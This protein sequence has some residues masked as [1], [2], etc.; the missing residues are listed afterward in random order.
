M[1]ITNKDFLHKNSEFIFQQDFDTVFGE[2]EF[3]IKLHPEAL[4]LSAIQIGKPFKAFIIKDGNK[5][6]RFANA[7]ISKTKEPYLIKEGCLSLPGEEYLVQRFKIVKTIDIING[8]KTL[9]GKL[10]Q[11]FLHEFDHTRGILVSDIQ[12]STKLIK[13]PNC[14]IKNGAKKAI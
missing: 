13:T 10:A 2:L 14:F 1:I 5:F 8:P 7:T 6:L 11:V 9:K 12:V 4:G 3:E